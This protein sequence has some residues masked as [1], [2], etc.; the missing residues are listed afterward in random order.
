V[1]IVV[2]IKQVVMGDQVKTDPRTGTLVRTAESSRMNPF[3]LF[4]LDLAVRIKKELSGCV[5]VV[6]MGPDI[7]EEVLWEALALG[8]DRAILL[9]DRRFAS[10]DTLATSYVLGMAIRKIASVDLVLCGKGTA[11]SDTGQVGPQLGEELGIPHLTG[12]EKLERRDRLFR[13]ER[14]SDGYRETIEL[15]EPCVL[16]VAPTGEVR[17]PSLVD[18][19]DAFA[20]F[21][22]ARWTLEDIQADPAKVGSA[23]SRTWVEQLIPSVHGKSCVFIDGDSR[24]QAKSLLDQ[25]LAQGLLS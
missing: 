20:K 18:I 19:Q 24:Q 4:A 23:G 25:L 5:T 8:A 11:D 17:V 13:V 7:S 14:L 16:S 3:D 9:T 1:N 6:T 15:A 12:V 10:G 22:I 21:S 2:C